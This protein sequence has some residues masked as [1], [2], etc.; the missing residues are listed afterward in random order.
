DKLVL[1]ASVAAKLY[2]IEAGSEATEAAMAKASFVIAPD[3]L[4][5]EIANV[6]AKHVRRRTATPAA[7]AS[8]VATASTLLDEAVP[9]RDLA[10]RAFTMAAEHGFSAYDGAYLALA[11]TRGLKLLTAD[12]HLARR[13]GEVGLGDLVWLLG[14]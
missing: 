13:A 10:S 7:A 8:A 11:E 6:A 5:L 12:V 14:D 4:H 3:L 1:D 2:F 9:A